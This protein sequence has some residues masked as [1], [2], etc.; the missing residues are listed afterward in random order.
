MIESL[1]IHNYILVDHILLKFNSGFTVFTGETGAG[2]SI[3]VGALKILAGEKLSSAYIRP[4]K[5]EARF[6]VVWNIEYNSEIHSF[7][8]E[9][10]LPC[11]DERVIV[12]RSI[13]VGGKASSYI[14][15]QQVTQKDLEYLSALLVDQHS[16]HE[17]QSL[18][19]SQVQRNLLDTYAGCTGEV[20]NITQSYHL[21]QELH[22][23]LQHQRDLLES[24]AGE[25]KYL[26][27]AI[28]E[29]G[30]AQLEDN[31]DEK[32]E[33]ELR[34]LANCEEIQDLCKKSTQLLGEEGGIVAGL[35]QVLRFLQSLNGKSSTFGNFEERIAALHIELR[36]VH[37]ELEEKSAALIFDPSHLVTVEKRLNFIDLLKSKYGKSIDAIRMFKEAALGKLEQ[38]DRSNEN[39]AGITQ[40]LK[41][42][43]ER[44]FRLSKKVSTKRAQVAQKLTGEITERLKK[45]GMPHARL[46]VHTQILKNANGTAQCGPYGIDEMRFLFTANAGAQQTTLKHAASGGE[47][48]RIMLA[49]KSVFANEDMIPTLI[50]D[51]VDAGIGGEIALQVAEHL[52][53]LAAAKQVLCITHLASLATY[54]DHHYQV[55]KFVRNNET[56]TQAR[57]VRDEERVS[58]IARMLSG[59]SDARESRTHARSLLEKVHS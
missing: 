10:D 24:I 36:D 31:E 11:D 57:V 49:I 14:Q 5:T 30:K 40:R 43:E 56:F 6:T 45:L 26:E 3:L 38:L 32:L 52:K 20:M 50:F 28:E 34:V 42:E 19:L 23:E 46:T 39:L 27:H 35:S 16:Q 18:F 4:G 51:E 37:T 41:A 29:I 13:R 2:K 9:R 33:E 44:L 53:E 54:A 55:T 47:L 7:L 59:N 8:Q 22:Q 12:R 17:H 48:S 58:E 25:K 15:S 21:V 1:E